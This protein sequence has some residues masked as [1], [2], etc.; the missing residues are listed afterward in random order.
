MGGF[1]VKKN[2]GVGRN[3]YQ[4]KISFSIYLVISNVG[5]VSC[6][7]NFLLVPFINSTS[8]VFSAE[9]REK[10]VSASSASLFP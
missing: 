8:G 5:I 3:K 2:F 1:V 9:L 6:S 4:L 7:T 10:L